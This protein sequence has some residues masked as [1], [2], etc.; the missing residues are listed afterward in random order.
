MADTATDER[1]NQQNEEDSQHIYSPN[2]VATN[3]DQLCKELASALY[4]GET[5]RSVRLA[6]AVAGCGRVGRR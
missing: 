3:G 1:Q 4:A 2:V 6:V 5:P